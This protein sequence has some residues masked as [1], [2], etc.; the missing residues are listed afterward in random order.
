MNDDNDRPRVPALGRRDLLKLGAGVVL[1]SMTAQ[2][3]SSQERGRGSRSPTPPRRS[4][5]PTG[6][7]PP[8]TGPRYKN[9]YNPLGGNG[10]MD[11]ATPAIVKLVHGDHASDLTPA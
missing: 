5:P 2:Q 4:A 8:H 3:A 11:D 7:L 9:D 1:T 10:P 6:E